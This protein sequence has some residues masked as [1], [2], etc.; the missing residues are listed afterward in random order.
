[1]IKAWNCLLV[2][3][4]L[5]LTALLGLIVLLAIATEQPESI[6]DKLY[7]NTHRA[8]GAII[9]STTNI[10]LTKRPAP[11]TTTVKS[12]TTRHPNT[13]EHTLIP[14][15][16]ELNL[17]N[18]EKIMSIGFYN[19]SIFY[20]AKSTG[21]VE[22]FKDFQPIQTF[23]I[24]AQIHRMVY[25]N[26]G[27]IVVVDGQNSTLNLVDGMGQ[28]LV[29]VKLGYQAL[30]LQ[31]SMNKIYVL[32]RRNKSIHVY[33][34]KLMEQSE[35]KLDAIKES[36][37]NFILPDQAFV[38]LSCEDGVVKVSNVSKKWP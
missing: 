5:L 7:L 29:Q 15:P 32:S 9:E 6:L 37:C 16:T 27:R 23:H 19:D 17:T 2:I 24:S 18:S 1:M 30:D 33:D 25:L 4:I 8:D 22:L 10:T 14:Y 31:A 26:D 13:T 12:T 38:Y 36:S 28:I 34:N 35:I 11:S 21:E 3:C 20:V